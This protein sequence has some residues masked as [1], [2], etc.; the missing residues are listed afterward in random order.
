[1]LYSLTSVFNADIPTTV[2]DLGMVD[3]QVILV[4]NGVVDGEPWHVVVA[5]IVDTTGN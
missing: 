5:N 4:N 3:V 1:M 2:G